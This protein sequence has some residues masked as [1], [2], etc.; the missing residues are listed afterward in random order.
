MRYAGIT[1]DAQDTG[2]R[3]RLSSRTTLHLR[4]RQVGR[5]PRG[6]VEEPCVNE[7]C[8]ALG[9]YGRAIDRPCERV[10][11]DGVGHVLK[12]ANVVDRADVGVELAI[13]DGVGACFPN[14][15]SNERLWSWSC[16][17][18][19]IPS[20]GANS[21]VLP[22]LEQSGHQ[23]EGTEGRTRTTECLKHTH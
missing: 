11:E 5:H 4:V 14:C 8:G 16:S 10:V 18:E 12:L 22:T 7:A 3:A 19:C 15:T 23:L 6:L 2:V 9:V 1:N 13:S 17:M 20:S 21:V